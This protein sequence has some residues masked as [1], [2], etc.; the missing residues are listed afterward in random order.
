MWILQHPIKQI[1]NHNNPHRNNT[2][3]TCQEL[4]FQYFFQNQCFWQRQSYDCHHE[5]KACA[6][7]DTF[8]NEGLNNGDDTAGIGIQWDSENDCEWHAPDTSFLQICFKK[9]LWHVAVDECTDSNASKNIEC[10]FFCN[11]H[12]F[13]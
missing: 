11:I 1:P 13:F 10:N 7:R 2:K 12:C 9:F 4:P 8:C 3:K 6:D 5:G